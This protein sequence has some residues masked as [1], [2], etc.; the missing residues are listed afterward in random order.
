MGRRDGKKERKEMGKAD[1]GGTDE[2]RNGKNE[3]RDEKQ[4]I[5]E[6]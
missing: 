4:Q 6:K 2:R 5:N 1:G 3:P